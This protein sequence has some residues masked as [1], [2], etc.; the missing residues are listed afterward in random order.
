MSPVL[1]VVGAFVAMEGVSYA[2]HRWV[3][4]GFGLGWHRSHHAP[5]TSRFERNDLFP[6]CFS[7]VGVLLFALGSLGLDAM[8]WVAVGVTSLRGRATCS[9]T[10]CTS[11]IGSPSE[12][13]G[14]ATWSGCATRTASTTR[15][16]PSPTACSSR[17]CASRH[18]PAPPPPTRWSAPSTSDRLARRT[19]PPPL[20]RTRVRK[21]AFLSPFAPEFV[22]SAE[23]SAPALR[24]ATGED[25]LGAL[26]VVAL[27]GDERSVDD[28][29]VGGHEDQT[30]R[31]GSRGRTPGRTPSPA[32][33]R[34]PRGG[35]RRRTARGRR[36]SRR[37]LTPPAKSAP[38][39]GRRSFQRR[40]RRR[41]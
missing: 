35:S 8:W 37:L 9:S 25:A 21:D 28:D 39:S 31:A 32:S 36:A 33:G 23:L 24:R 30:H 7:A 26:A 22:G 20:I 2:A 29:A 27:D 4:H 13:R 12:C 18:P 40:I 14:F 19:S 17:S 1:L 5:A 15:P 10:R 3:M 16:A 34:T 6:V 41:S 11:T 38:A